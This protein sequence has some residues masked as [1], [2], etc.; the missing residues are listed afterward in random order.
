[1]KS[2]REDTSQSARDARRCAIE[3]GADAMRDEAS[4]LM[5]SYVG[6][7]KTGR[8]DAIVAH[9]VFG[10]PKLLSDRTLAPRQPRGGRVG[11]L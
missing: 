11:L 1:M 2:G 6:T 5:N 7:G 8:F 3:R 9:V 4:A 10:R